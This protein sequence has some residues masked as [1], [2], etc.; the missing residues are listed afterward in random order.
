[1]HGPALPARP[2]E[3]SSPVDIALPP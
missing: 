1:M 2:T 3:I